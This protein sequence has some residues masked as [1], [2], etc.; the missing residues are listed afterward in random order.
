MIH[1]N[2]DP[3]GHDNDIYAAYD[4]LGPARQ[5][6]L[7]DMLDRK[8]ADLAPGY[9]KRANMA[10]THC[11]VCE[12]PWHGT[13]HGNMLPSGLESTHIWGRGWLDKGKV[14]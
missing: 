7:E 2:K 11:G 3:A 5:N 1:V 14:G 9:S 6:S 4:S 13:L 10:Q 8:R 12:H